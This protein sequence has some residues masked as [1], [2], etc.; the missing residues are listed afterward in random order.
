MHISEITSFGMARSIYAKFEISGLL[1]YSI[2]IS[3]SYP[4]TNLSI[5]IIPRTIKRI[6]TC[7]G[8]IQLT[9]AL[10][11]LFHREQAQS[12]VAI[13]YENYLVIYGLYAPN[14][15]DHKFAAFIEKMARSV[16]DWVSI[17]YLAP[18]KFDA[19]AQQLNTTSPKKI[20]ETVYSWVGIDQADEL[21]LCRNWQFTN[22]LFLNAY[23]S[24]YKICYGDGIGIYFSENSSVVRLPSIVESLPA[25]R[26][27]PLQWSY[28]KARTAW[29]RIRERLQLKTV[30]SS[31]EFDIGYFLLPN[32]F[33]E[34]PPM[35]IEV[36]QRDRLLQVLQSFTPL[37]DA[38]RV[39]EFR[40]AIADA[41]IS[42]LLTSNLSEA[43]RLSCQDELNAYREFLQSQGINSNSILVIKPHPRDDLQKIHELRSTLS[44]LYSQ[45]IILD[46]LEL[47]FL[48]F[49]VFFLSA[50]SNV[51]SNSKI[52]IFAVSSACLSLKL[53]FDVESVTGFGSEITSQYFS[54]E[55]VE[56]RL[57]H[58]QILVE[59][60]AQLEQ[61]Q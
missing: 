46:S 11:V 48:P 58:E 36:L 19:I 22:Q 35:S 1:N 2:V 42:I 6:I 21:Y 29:H 50:F 28:C 15:Q 9:T 52:R 4:Q 20:F 16:C 59:A 12:N 3:H 40:A 61:I 25:L 45:V 31:I 44:G 54:S 47:F 51:Q 5:P 43:E 7:Q 17:V 38:E 33:G 53:L 37:L 60:L 41:P 49:E 23:A 14:K 32:I 10:T 24:A 39:R 27:S 34:V 56:A 55:Y 13:T 18:E 8:S 30:L 26:H 57:E